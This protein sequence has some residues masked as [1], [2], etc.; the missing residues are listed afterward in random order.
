MKPFSGQILYNH[1]T[2]DIDKKVTSSSAPD[3]LYN[4]TDSLLVHFLTAESW[5]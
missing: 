1:Y 2:Q 5:V 4:H 3:K